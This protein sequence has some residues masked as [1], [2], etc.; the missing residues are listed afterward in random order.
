MGERSELIAR[1]LREEG[2]KMLTY[3][4]VLDPAD[5]EREIYPRPAEGGAEGGQPWNLRQLV[6]H[7]LSAERGFHRMALDVVAGGQGAPDEMDIGEFNTAE[8]ARLE[9]SPPADLLAALEQVRKANVG[10]V[11]SLSEPDLDQEGRHP[12]FGRASLG[13]QFK[14]IYRHNM[15]HLRDPKRV[16]E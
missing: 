9:H 14:L 8:V 5:W 4:R 15:L 10:L 3:L 1:R 16:L 2:Q 6:A 7:Q 12:F 11:E 13:K